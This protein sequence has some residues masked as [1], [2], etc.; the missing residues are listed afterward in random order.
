MLSKEC[1]RYACRACTNP[2]CIHSCHPVGVEQP[3]LLT[4]TGTGTPAQNTTIHV[5]SSPS[6]ESSRAQRDEAMER[7]EANAEMEWKIEAKRALWRRIRTKQPF[8]TDDLWDD[9]LT[10]PREP[11]ALGP[12]V[13]TAKRKG[14][15]IDTGRMVQSRYRHATKVTV[16]QGA[17]NV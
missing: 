4:S 6:I 7:V 11:R 12:I 10:K 2:A 1:R 17:E 5:T 8:T 13:A 9:G 14:Y 16:W 15:L 3:S